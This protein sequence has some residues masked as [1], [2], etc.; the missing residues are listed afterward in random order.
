MEKKEFSNIEGDFKP[1]ASGIPAKLS[2]FSSKAF[3]II[4]FILGI[5]LLPFVYAVSVAFLNEFSIVEASWQAYFWSG[6]ITL[7]I[8][9]LF[10]WEPVIVYTKG[11]RLLE[12]FFNFFKP[13]LRVAPYLLPIYTII[14]FIIYSLSSLVI[15]SSWLLS[16]SVFLIGFTVALHLVFSARSI[17]SKKGD[18]L[19]ANYIFG[20][21]FV[22]IINLIIVAIFMNILFEKFSFINFSNNSLQLAKNIFYTV[23]KQLFL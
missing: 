7:L 21:S 18:F 19:K 1:K 14:L 15:K 10:I 4:K 9:Y 8:I 2:G 13:L 17:R 12:A 22:Y 23:F 6:I 5:S 3:G 11:Q 20:F 16:Y